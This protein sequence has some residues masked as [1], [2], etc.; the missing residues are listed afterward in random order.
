[1][2]CR[3]LPLSVLAAITLLSCANHAWAGAVTTFNLSQLTVSGTSASFDV[4]LTFSGA[5][6]D[7]IEA[8]QLSVFGSSPL[9]T[10]GDTDFSRFGFVPNAS[11]LPGWLEF[12]PISTGLAFYAPADPINGPFL[13]PSASPIDLGIL[14]VDLTGLPPNTDLN[15]TLN[16]GPAG[17]GT[18]LAGTIAGM[19]AF[20]FANADPAI[21]SLQFAQP[22]GVSFATPATS[23]PEPSTFSLLMYGLFGLMVG[24]RRCRNVR[25]T[26]SLRNRHSA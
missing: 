12:S 5:P 13:S 25:C 14:S 10:N 23:V 11:S 15:V 24:V 18:D 16:G 2:R 6:T 1:M 8:L 19:T 3:C 22:D 17:L 9:L 26:R 7:T 4:S 21:V 20:S